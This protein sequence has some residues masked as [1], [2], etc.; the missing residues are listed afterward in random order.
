VRLADTSL[1]VRHTWH[2]VWV[3]RRAAETEADTRDA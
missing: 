1:L 3:Q 2:K